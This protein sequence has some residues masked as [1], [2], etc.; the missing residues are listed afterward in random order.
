MI[1]LGTFLSNN[2]LISLKKMYYH[3]QNKYYNSYIDIYKT[4]KDIHRIKKRSF[5]RSSKL[6]WPVDITKLAI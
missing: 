1:F 4:N 6:E 2:L 5:K 3:Y